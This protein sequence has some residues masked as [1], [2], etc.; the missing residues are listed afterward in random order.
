MKWYTG[1]GSRK[2]P[3]S[4]LV[5]MV[6]IARACEL[7]KIGLRSGGA[8]GADRAFES[9]AG[10]SLISYRPNDVMSERAYE[11]AKQFYE[12]HSIREFGRRWSSVKPYV[13][14]LMTRNVYQ[15]LGDNLDDPSRFLIC[16]TP[17]GCESSVTRTKATG[18]TGQAIA[19]ATAFQVEIINLYNADALG[20]VERKLSNESSS[21]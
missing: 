7:N 19:V 17:D 5:D 13:K 10:N 21:I 6:D 16:W 20:R 12:P 14:N 4:V 1:I 15:V 8:I 2:T 18:G 9:G 11:L 3:P